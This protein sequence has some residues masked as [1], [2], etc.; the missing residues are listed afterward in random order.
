MHADVVR[1]GGLAGL[2]MRGTVDTDTL[3]TGVRERVEA[4]LRALPFGQ[5][6][7]PPTHPDSF[8]FE[9]TVRDDGDQ[10]TA[11]VDESQ[12]PPEL[13]S[14]LGSGLSPGA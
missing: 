7:A 6:A 3:G 10:R 8:S 14:V 11:T 5:P 1:R 12:L 9:I 4:A 2:A 13:A